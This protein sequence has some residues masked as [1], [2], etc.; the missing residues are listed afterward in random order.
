LT[1]KQLLGHIQILILGTELTKLIVSNNLSPREYV[2]NTAAV[3][4]KFQKGCFNPMARKLVLSFY[5]KVSQ[6]TYLVIRFYSNY[7][8]KF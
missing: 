1:L 7:I 6:Y 5:Q 4:T 3:L 8:L 2:R